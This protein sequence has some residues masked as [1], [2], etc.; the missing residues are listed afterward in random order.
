MRYVALCLCQGVWL[1]GCISTG[2]VTFP[3]AKQIT[4]IEVFEG[5]ASENAPQ[6]TIRDPRKIAAI[7]AFLH[8]HEGK[9][10]ENNIAT[11]KGK[12]HIRFVGNDVHLSLRTG[13]GVLQVQGAD[14]GLHYKDLSEDEQETLLTL[15]AV[16]RVPAPVLD[17][18]Q[19]ETPRRTKAWDDPRAI[20]AGRVDRKPDPPEKSTASSLAD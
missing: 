9:W 8:D 3:P 4:S 13:N 1:S 12:Y 19:L 14:Y 5:L 2:L 17:E 15:L 18:V 16:P 20:Q 7:L 6:R 11:E 10:D